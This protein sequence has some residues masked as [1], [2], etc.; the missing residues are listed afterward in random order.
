MKQLKNYMMLL[1]L[2]PC[3]CMAQGYKPA[4]TKPMVTSDHYN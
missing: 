1:L 3:F 2:V 4:S